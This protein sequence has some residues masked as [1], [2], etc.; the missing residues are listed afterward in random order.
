VNFTFYLAGN[1]SLLESNKLCVHG[2]HIANFMKLNVN[3]MKVIS[4]SRKPTVSVL[5]ENRVNP[6]SHAI[7]ASDIWEYLLAPNSM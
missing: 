2:W 7:I 4:F 3:K 6:L 1:C 5:I